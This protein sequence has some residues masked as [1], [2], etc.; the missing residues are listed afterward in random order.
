VGQSFPTVDVNAA[1]P[2]LLENARLR[3]MPLRAVR[4]AGGIPA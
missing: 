2:P 1:L 3:D 4:R